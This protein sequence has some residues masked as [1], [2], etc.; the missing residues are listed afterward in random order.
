[1]VTKCAWRGWILHHWSNKRSP[2]REIN[3]FSLRN[4]SF[5]VVAP[6]NIIVLEDLVVSSIGD[7][8]FISAVGL[9][10][11][12]GIALFKNWIV[13]L[14]RRSSQNNRKPRHHPSVLGHRLGL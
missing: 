10:D 6:N 1:M 2:R 9:V 11:A 8:I 13:M 4:W 5:E 7:N 14:G 3:F 12:S